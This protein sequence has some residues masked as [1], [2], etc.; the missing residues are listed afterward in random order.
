MHFTGLVPDGA[1]LLAGLD[2]YAQTSRSE[3][4]SIAMLE[5]MAAGLPT[6]ASALD[7]VREIHSEGKTALLVPPSDTG[8]IAD[9]LFRLCD[10]VQLRRRLGAAAREAV[11][12]YS[13]DHTV[14]AYVALY[15]EI[16]CKARAA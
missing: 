16:A 2:I 13:I 3:G 6:V 1:R 11:Q 7:P 8:P 14:D 9:A 15:R 4:R 5:A 12:R 10:D